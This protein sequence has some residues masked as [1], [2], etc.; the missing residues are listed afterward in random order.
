MA[1]KPHELSIDELTTLGAEAAKAAAMVARRRGI[2]TTGLNADYVEQSP[3]RETVK[4]A[5]KLV[6]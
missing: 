5:K 4:A 3:S 6:S 1:K 2:V